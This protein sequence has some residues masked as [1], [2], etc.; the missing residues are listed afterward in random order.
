MP[1]ERHR[2][3]EALIEKYE[4]TVYKLAYSY[5]RNKQDSD[6]IYQEVFLRYFRNNPEF[7]GEEH[8]KAWF[9]RVTIN[10]CKDLLKNFF[11]SH[12]VSLERVMD[13]AQPPN[14][15][16]EYREVLKAVLSLPQKYRDVTYL[17]Y[18]EEYTAPEISN[19]LGKNVN[20]VYTLLTRSRQMLGKVRR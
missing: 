11:R 15:S 6:D 4:K 10:A 9:I 8:E 19:I 7:A 17:H 14:M 18:Y 16:S 20:T 12:F 3:I 1:N 5:L 2:Q 13:M